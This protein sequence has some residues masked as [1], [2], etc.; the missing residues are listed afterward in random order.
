MP[1]PGLDCDDLNPCS[2]E[3][4]DA[5]TGCAHTPIL[6]CPAAVPSPFGRRSRILFAL[7]LS[8]VALLLGEGVQF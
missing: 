1:G 3:S 6:G 7:I 4:C 2:A 5:M 8:A